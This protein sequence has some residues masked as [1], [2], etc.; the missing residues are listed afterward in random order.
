MRKVRR[1]VLAAWLISGLIAGLLLA[2]PL[3]ALQL[4]GDIMLAGSLERLVPLAGLAG[5]AI[6][7]AGILDYCRSLVLLRAGLW[8]DH[9]LAAAFLEAGLRQRAEGGRLRATAD[10]FT[11]VRDALV[12]GRL[13]SA[14]ELPWSLATCACILLLDRRLGLI[15]LAVVGLAALG[16]L[17]FRSNPSKQRSQTGR[18]RHWLDQL[19]GRS[20]ELSAAGASDGATRR[21]E[22]MNA[23]TL[24]PRYAAGRK[25]GAGLALVRMLQPAGTAC[26]LAFGVHA[27]L[28]TGL[29]PAVVVAAA[30]VVARALGVMERFAAD[31]NEVAAARI[32][33]RILEHAESEFAGT[34]APPATQLAP[35]FGLIELV[36]VTCRPH[37]DR[38]PLLSDVDLWLR[39][40]EC[41]GII[42]NRGSGKTSLARTIAGELLPDIGSVTIDG[43]SLSVAQRG[44]TARGIGFLSDSPRL[45]AG[46]IADNIAGFEPHEPVDLVRAASL[47]GV[48]DKIERLPH[49]YATRVDELGAPLSLRQSRAVA[50]ARALYG[51]P[52]F[53]VLDEPEIG[54]DAAEIARLVEV[55]GELRRAGIGIALAT[56]EP[57][58]LALTDRIVL[59]ESGRIEAILPSRE[60]AVAQS[61][62]PNAAPRHVRQ[63]A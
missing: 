50:F 2:L 59:L 52:S 46:T 20:A 16:L 19:A 28:E 26:V 42:G 21:W 11:S 33:W 31:R 39:S 23:S 43:L 29:G 27:V 47:A 51:S 55:L 4:L 54:A 18:A 60:L 35:A 44:M 14:L 49:G 17:V 1:A 25:Q 5:A 41:I 32:G 9:T 58:L 45:L 24:A 38:A 36:G 3:F 48:H 57:R 12:H 37:G 56:G 15:S 22:H 61:P 13:T 53:V 40:G 62:A 30:L 6:L 63:A 7:A 8:L 10:A 34:S